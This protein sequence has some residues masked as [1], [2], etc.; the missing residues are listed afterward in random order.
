MYLT[1]FIA[2][3]SCDMQVQDKK[4]IDKWVVSST[5]WYLQSAFWGGKRGPILDLLT[6]LKA[7]VDVD[8]SHG[9]YSQ[10]VQ[11]ERCE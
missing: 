10:V 1:M 7:R 9:I 8:R 11:D 3:T 4:G 5:A 2:A 6:D